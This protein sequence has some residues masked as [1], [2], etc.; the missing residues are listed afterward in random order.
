MLQGW[1]L[2]VLDGLE[3]FSRQVAA[4]PLRTHVNRR[5]VSLGPGAGPLLAFT[6]KYWQRFA[7][8]NDR[9]CEQKAHRR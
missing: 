7:A 3:M 6:A 8:M 5:S 9:R 4:P 1:R 2:D